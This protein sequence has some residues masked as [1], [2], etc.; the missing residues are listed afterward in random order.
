MGSAQSQISSLET[1][2]SRSP[3]LYS[4]GP[5][6]HSMGAVPRGEPLYKN[7][8]MLSLERVDGVHMQGGVSRGIGNPTGHKASL[9]LQMGRVNL[10][11]L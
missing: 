9:T 5:Q 6:Y 8:A 11:G 7:E 2:T 10:V 4:L 3:S 1:V